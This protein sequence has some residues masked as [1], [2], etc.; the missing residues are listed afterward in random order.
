MM[1]PSSFSGED[2]E[3]PRVK[4]FK[5]MKKQDLVEEA[6]EQSRKLEDQAARLEKQDK[7]LEKL[8]G[9]VE[10]PV[11]LTLP[12]EAP[13]PCNRGNKKFYNVLLAQ[14]KFQLV[15]SF[16]SNSES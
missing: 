13:V 12:V 6:M 16:A 11:C 15:T 1:D 2:G 9:M 8:K 14:I 10:C 7:L 5:Q 4:R 3:G